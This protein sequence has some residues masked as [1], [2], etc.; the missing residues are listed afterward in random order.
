M[1]VAKAKSAILWSGADILLKQGLQFGVSIALARLLSPEQFGTVALLYLFL[2][3]AGGF[4][5][6]GLS[7]ALI[8]KREVTS[9]DESTVFWFNLSMGFLVAM[10]LFAAAPAIAGFY[11]LP[12]LVPLTRLMSLNIVLGALGSIHGTLLS[13]RL[14]FRT[15]MKISGLATVCSGTVAV[16][17][18]WKGLGVWALAGQ[19]LASTIAT[20]VLLWIF[21]PWR[22]SWVFSL[23]SA[24]R[25][26]GFGGYVFA[27]VM[28]YAVHSRVYTLLIG[29]YFSTRELGFY[30]RAS[31]TQQLP[32][33]LLGIV[34]G[35]VS[36]PLFSEAAQDKT[37][38]RRGV[39]MAL[40]GMMLVNVPAMFG[41]AA[42]AEPLLL[43]LF[44]AKWLPAVPLLRALCLGGVLVPLHGVNLSAL[45]AQGRP[46]L[47]FF[48]EIVKSALSLLFL[49]GGSLFGV[50]GIAWGVGCCGVVDFVINAH[51]TQRSLGYGALAQLRDFLPIIAASVPMALGV[52]YLGEFWRIA[53]PIKLTVQVA[54]GAVGF[55]LTGWLVK[56][57]ALRDAVSLLRQ[58]KAVSA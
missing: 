11:H 17:L 8:Q 12:V 48:L 31:S 33:S 21:S 34:M 37:R 30:E 44:G 15:Q 25:L 52:Y 16:A 20:T 28:L 10:A 51:Y 26:L 42:T 3:I 40:R 1:L 2:G 46:D 13:K 29:R 14:D 5:D 9:T 55:L 7:T 35:R 22:P 27:A 19:T 41:V 50:V 54:S 24:R 38:L 45:V 4:V 56:L 47:Q 36:L 18:A 23:A 53:P 49:V 58:Q 57:T 39:Q 6:G 43:T 32:V